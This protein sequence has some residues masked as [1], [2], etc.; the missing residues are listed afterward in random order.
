MDDFKRHI[1]IYKNYFIKF[2][3]AQS[4]DVKKKI[5]WTIMLIRDVN[6]LLEKYFKRIVGT[7]GLWEIRVSVSGGNYRVFSFFDK[8]NLIILLGGFHKKNSKNSE[9]RN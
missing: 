6:I 5:D 4:L 1:K 3:V 7:D 8:G 2:Y 9:E